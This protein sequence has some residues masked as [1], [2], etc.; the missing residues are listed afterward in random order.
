MS[1]QRTYQRKA[2]ARRAQPAAEQLII[3]RAKRVVPISSP[4]SVPGRQAPRPQLTFPPRLCRRAIDHA[5]RT[6]CLPWPR[7]QA[8]R[9]DLRPERSEIQDSQP[10]TYQRYLA[11]TNQRAT[12]IVVDTR[13]SGKT[14]RPGRRLQG[15]RWIRSSSVRTRARLQILESVQD[16]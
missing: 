3:R 15:C 12:R 6:S 10:A 16:P 4:A 7:I 8:V 13:R 1:L 2:S 5:K 9:D 14:R 11:R